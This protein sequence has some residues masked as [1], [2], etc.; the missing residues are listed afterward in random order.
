MRKPAAPQEVYL[1]GGQHAVKSFS[2]L[3]MKKHAVEIERKH[4]V[5]QLE[6]TQPTS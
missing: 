4:F 3:T 6:I 5:R 1:P 2:V